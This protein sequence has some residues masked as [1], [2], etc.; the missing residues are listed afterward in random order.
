M[1]PNYPC[2]P[3]PPDEEVCCDFSGLRPGTVVYL[4]Y[5]ARL[6][7]SDWSDLSKARDNAFCKLSYLWQ[8]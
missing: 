3:I 4:G 6:E 1:Y 5:G 8:D 2:V 7:G